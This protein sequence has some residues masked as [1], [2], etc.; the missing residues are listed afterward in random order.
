MKT[1]IFFCS[2]GLAA[3]HIL[4]GTC[5][6]LTPVEDSFNATALNTKR[7]QLSQ[8]QNAK[9]RQAGERLNFLVRAS[10]PD[11]DYAFV[12]LINNQPGYNENW[13]LLLDVKNTTGQGDRVGVGFW[14][15]NADDP[16]D[17]VF[18]EFYGS[19]GKKE[20]NCVRASF[21][22]DGTHI[23]GDLN[24]KEKLTTSG[25]LKLTF[26]KQTKRFA[27]FFRS[28]EKGSNWLSLGTFSVNGVG[29]TTR[30]NWNMN[31]GSG[32]F[33]IRLEG[34]GENRV[35]ASGAANMDDFVLGALK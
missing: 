13:Q 26:N 7:W 27:F 23:A 10:T 25:R 20:R 16:S 33:G 8:F 22:L 28:D 17:V 15:F 6:A 31:P 2:L 9:L 34:Y 4:T 5:L 24:L 21:I 12:E 29:G 35:V 3:C 18:F 32:R 1:P 30:A 14:I 19:P 11:E